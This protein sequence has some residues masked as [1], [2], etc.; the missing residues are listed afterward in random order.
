M[1]TRRAPSAHADDRG[2]TLAAPGPG[3]RRR[4]RLAGFV[5]E[6]DPGSVHHLNTLTRGHAS[7][8]TAPPRRH[9][10]RSRAGWVAVRTSRTAVVAATCPR[11]CRRRGTCGRSSSSPGPGSTAGRSTRGTAG[12]TLT[13]APTCL[14]VCQTDE[15]DQAIPSTPPRPGPPRATDAASVPPTA[16]GPTTRQRSPDSSSR[17][18]S[19]PRPAAGPAPERPSRRPSSHHPVDIS[20][21]QDYR[22]HLRAVRRTARHHPIKF[23]SEK[24]STY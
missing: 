2:T 24:P 8:S 9:R 11:W 13:A 15:A 23:N 4:H 18:Q 21:H 22:S 14:S 7:A 1:E 19:T 17:P 3:A 6:D 16:P 5:L 10:V 20:P 12:R